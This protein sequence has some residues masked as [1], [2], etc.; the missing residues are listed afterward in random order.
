MHN[1]C[2]RTHSG[3]HG[4]SPGLNKPK[5]CYNIRPLSRTHFQSQIQVQL[6]YCSPGHECTP[7]GSTCMYGRVHRTLL[8]QE[9]T[10]KVL[11]FTCSQNDPEGKQTLWPQKMNKCSPSHKHS[12]IKSTKPLGPTSKCLKW[13]LAHCS[14]S[15]SQITT[16]AKVPGPRGQ[17]QM[18][19]QHLAHSCH[20]IAAPRQVFP[21][22][23]CTHPYHP[24]P[25][26]FQPQTLMSQ[27]ATVF[28]VEWIWTKVNSV[29]MPSVPRGGRLLAFIRDSPP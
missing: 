13:P 20:Q 5:Q 18:T 19:T 21:A 11:I 28:D 3:T 6:Y 22:Q 25:T 17:I 14:P 1:T 10:R 23:L 27:S 2:K 9:Y 8:L 16:S 15:K 29:R 12:T 26:P 7:T 24:K 4:G